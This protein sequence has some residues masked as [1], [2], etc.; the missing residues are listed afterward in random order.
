M[1]EEKHDEIIVK[2]PSKPVIAEEKKAQKTAER[3]L[4]QERLG[5][6]EVPKKIGNYLGTISLGTGVLLVGFLMYSVFSGQTGLIF[7]SSSSS[8]P[9]VFLWFFVGII[10]IVVGLLL[11]GSE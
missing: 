3:A 6:L 5:V 2:A 11:M 1:T 9:I 7:L 4:E 10:S 8:F